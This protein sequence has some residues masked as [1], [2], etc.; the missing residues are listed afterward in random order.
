ME[1][2]AEGFSQMEGGAFV[3]CQMGEPDQH[4]MSVLERALRKS[5]WRG[6]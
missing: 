2:V 6:P 5:G 1:D 4:G 3:L